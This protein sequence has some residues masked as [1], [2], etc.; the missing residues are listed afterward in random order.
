MGRPS[1]LPQFQSED[2]DF[3]LMQDRWASLLNP[4]LR[5]PMVNGILLEDV[6][7]AIG[8]NVINHRLGRTP[9]GWFLVDTDGATSIYRSAP[10]SFLTLT[11][12]SSATAN[13]KLW[14]F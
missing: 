3:R 6:T 2:K 12:N 8:D 7:L 9:Q 1:F 10:F 14:I 11:L 4:V 5:N 13:V